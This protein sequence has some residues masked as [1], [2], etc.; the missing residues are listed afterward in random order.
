[1]PLALKV[2]AA[3]MTSITDVKEWDRALTHMKNVD[4]VFVTTYG[5]IQQDLYEPLKLSYDHLP[6]SN[7][8][9]CFLYCG[10]FVED[11]NIHVE[12]LVEMWIAEG[13]VN[14]RGTNSLMDSGLRYVNFLAER[15]LFEKVGMDMV[16]IWVHDV[17]REMAIHIAETEENCLFR[18]SQKLQKFPV[19]PGIDHC[20]RI[21]IG[22]NN[23]PSL[24]TDFT[25]PNLVTLILAQNESLNK[26]PN[27]FLTNLTSLSVLD[28]SRTKIESLPISVCH[29]RQLEFLRLSYTS[30][31]D[32]PEEVSHLSQLQ[33]LHLFCC[34][35]LRSLPCGIGELQNLKHLNL[36]GCG[37]LAGIPRELSQLTSLEKLELMTGVRSILRVEDP[38]SSVC[39][40]KDLSNLPYLIELNVLVKPGMNTNGMRSG[41]KVDTM[42]AWLEMRHLTLKFDVKQHN[43]V[44]QDL[45]EDMQ[46]MKKLQV[47]NLGFYQGIKLPNCIC[48]F[49]QLEK[50]NLYDCYQLSE[51]PPLERLPNLKVLSLRMCIKLRELRI[52]M[53]GSA[54]GFPMLENLHLHCHC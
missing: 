48:N 35:E 50:L 11:E 43:V 46:S 22:Y 53:W 32:L 25:C 37:K 47:L 27:G 17:L 23:I 49:E 14:S 10:T 54:S 28:L 5:G 40:L 6:D 39:S 41:V 13:L 26:V 24:P 42:A 7:F 52:G 2:V 12:R 18:T 29:L 38:N 30:I 36:D 15:C 34:G 45:P 20:K 3:A 21:A 4:P 51:L 9:A 19:E 31:K 8:K 33:F 1:M 16:W 44:M